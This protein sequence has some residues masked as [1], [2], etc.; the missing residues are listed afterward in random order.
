[1]TEPIQLAVP[2]HGYAVIGNY[3]TPSP[4]FI[5]ELGTF[6]QGKKVLEIFAGNGYLA[7]ILN[8]RA[9]NIKATSLRAGHDAH[10]QGFYYFVEELEATA[11]VELYGETN[12]IFLV[13][14]PTVTTAVLQA[15]MAWGSQK[16]IVYIGEITDYSKGHLGGC[17]TDA[18]FEHILCCHTFLS[19]K[20]NQIESA[21]VIRL[22]A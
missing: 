11:A 1:M 18:F 8:A 2:T 17:A 12:D 16:D 14:W 9:I 21:K 22:R 6:L 7:G 10:Q 20:G 15:V 19:Y 4:A 3:W 13:S 5:D